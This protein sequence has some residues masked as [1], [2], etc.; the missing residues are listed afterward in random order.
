ME[1]VINN[2]EFTEVKIQIIKTIQNIYSQITKEIG[3]VV[4]E[5]PS[6][7]LTA[8]LA[9]VMELLKEIREYQK[10]KMIMGITYN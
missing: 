3:S 6:E 10:D 7:K 4:E 5:L 2:K 9:I 8:H 1:A